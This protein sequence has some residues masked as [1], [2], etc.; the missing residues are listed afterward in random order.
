MCCGHG[1]KPDRP[2][3]IQWKPGKGRQQVNWIVCVIVWVCVLRTLS[4]VKFV[5]VIFA[6][7]VKRL[8]SL[9]KPETIEVILTRYEKHVS[10]VCL[11]KT[12]HHSARVF[13]VISS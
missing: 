3:P 8:L 4:I 13:W 6:A 9:D 12:G 5:F 7:L 10:A 1:R 2:P 11:C